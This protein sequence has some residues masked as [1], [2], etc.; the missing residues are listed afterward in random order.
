M[1]VRCGCFGAEGAFSA[2]DRNDIRK[3][4]ALLRSVDL[5]ASFWPLPHGFGLRWKI[6][7]L[8]F[9]LICQSEYIARRQRPTSMPSSFL[10][11][12]SAP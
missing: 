10:E 2:A 3:S 1:Q 12:R 8:H 5:E 6:R 4:D 7:P 9:E 11:L